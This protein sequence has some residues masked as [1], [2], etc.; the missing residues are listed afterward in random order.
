MILLAKNLGGYCR[1]FERDI[2]GVCY[3]DKRAVDNYKIIKKSWLIKFFLRIFKTKLFWKWKRLRRYIYRI[4]IIDIK[5]RKKKYNKRW[6]SIRLTRLYF[7]TLQDHQFR[8][9]FTRARKLTGDLESNYCH[10]LEG[11]LLPLFYRTN[12]LSNIFKVISFIKD[13]NVFLNFININYVNYTVKISTYISFNKQ[14]IKKI[15]YQLNQ[16][17]KLKAVLFNIPRFLFVSFKFWFCFL[18]KKPKKKDLVYPI[19]IDIQRIT[20]YY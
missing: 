6:L 16:R 12:Y 3:T 7:L 11:R 13:S 9:L 10:L 5:Q 20:G 19:S 14:Y 18:I 17:I 15:K 8:K 4:D 1:R 2:W